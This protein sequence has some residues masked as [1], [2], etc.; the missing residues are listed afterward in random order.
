MTIFKIM[1]LSESTCSS[2]GSPNAQSEF[3]DRN[4]CRSPPFDETPTTREQIDRTITSRENIERS[5]SSRENIDGTILSRESID[6]TIPTRE[7]MDITSSSRDLQHIQHTLPPS[8]DSSKLKFGVDRILSGETTCLRRPK[9]LHRANNAESLQTNARNTE[10]SILS[11]IKGARQYI[12]DTNNTSTIQKPT[13]LSNES[14]SSHTPCSECVTSLFRCCRLS[15][16][17]PRNQDSLNHQNSHL[18]GSLGQGMIPGGL[19]VTSS[20]LHHGMSYGLSR[21]VTTS[22]NISD[23]LQLG[24]G[25]HVPASMRHLSVRQMPGW[26]NYYIQLTLIY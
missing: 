18:V 15:P 19:P 14:H 24:Y 1:S 7:S 20:V 25:V 2:I 5:M 8:A 13:N 12:Q 23:G 9:P 11:L 16:P 6:R 22:S 17:L 21:F 4:D 3:P 10:F 26:L